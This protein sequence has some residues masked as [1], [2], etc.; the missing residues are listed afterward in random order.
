MNERNDRKK[1]D[2]NIG[3]EGWINHYKRIFKDFFSFHFSKT[4][5]SKLEPLLGRSN[6]CKCVKMKLDEKINK[7]KSGT[8]WLLRVVWIA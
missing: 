5:S 6:A 3:G 2:L 4:T 7:T 8:S 1:K